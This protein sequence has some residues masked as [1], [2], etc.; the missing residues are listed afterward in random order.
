MPLYL[1]DKK[2][3]GTPIGIWNDQGSSYYIPGQA[4]RAKQA[5]TT[6]NAKGTQV[7]WSEWADNLARSINHRTWW[8]TIDTPELDMTKVLGELRDHQI[9]VDNQSVTPDKS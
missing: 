3:D 4:A 7:P 8:A 1:V 2:F 5:S 6:V 9:A